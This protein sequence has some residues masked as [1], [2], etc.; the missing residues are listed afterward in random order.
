MELRDFFSR[1]LAGFSSVD[2]ISSFFSSA[3]FFPNCFASTVIFLDTSPV[4]VLISIF[5]PT[6]LFSCLISTFFCNSN[7]DCC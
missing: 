6:A 5:T 7:F 4:D 2:L 3:I 1:S